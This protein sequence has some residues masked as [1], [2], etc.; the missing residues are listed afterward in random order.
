[1]SKTYFNLQKIDFMRVL[2]ASLAFLAFFS[3]FNSQ[4]SVNTCGPTN[5]GSSCTVTGGSTT[6]LR[7]LRILSGRFGDGVRLTDPYDCGGDRIYGSVEG[8]VMPYTLTLRLEGSNGRILNKDVIVNA[9][10]QDWHSPVSYDSSSPD[11]VPT[12]N[13]RITSSV[14]DDTGATDTFTYTAFIRSGADCLTSNNNNS[15]NL[16]LNITGQNTD[17]N[18]S[19]NGGDAIKVVRTYLLRTGGIAQENPVLFSSS[20]LLMAHGASLLFI[21]KP[22]KIY[23]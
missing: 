11:Y 15:T 8:G 6:T 4:I 18:N 1:M 7:R 10:G 19:Q 16:T 9:N 20:V 2:L 21:K 12:G 13:Y 3:N 14:V 23:R 17:Q 5:T 22:K